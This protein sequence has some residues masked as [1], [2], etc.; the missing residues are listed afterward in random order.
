MA[1]PG[2][3][4]VFTTRSRNRLY[5]QDLL[6]PPIIGNSW[7]GNLKNSIRSFAADYRRLKLDWV[8]EQRSIKDKLDRAVLAGDSGQVNIAKAKLASLQVKEHQAWVVRARLKR[9][10]C[11][12]TN[13]VHEL[14]AEELRHAADQHIASVTSPD[15]QHQTTNEAVCKEFRQYFLK[16][17]TRKLLSSTP[18][19]PTSLASW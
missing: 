13:M 11:K 16:L 14:W 1:G 17:F 3:E 18:I 6:D 19:S 12:A 9:M 2:A 10:S 7:W 4:I 5:D 8:S 15:R